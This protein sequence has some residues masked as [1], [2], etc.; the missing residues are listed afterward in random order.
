MEL[1]M[2]FK[3]KE[4]KIFERALEFDEILPE[5]FRSWLHY[6]VI[7]FLGTYIMVNGQINE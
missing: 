2:S 7:F 3:P 1:I 6:M 4:R 5:S